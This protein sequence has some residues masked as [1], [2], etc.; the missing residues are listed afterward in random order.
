MSRSE[1]KSA[2]NY[3]AVFAGGIGSRMGSSSTPKQFLKLGGKPIV[4]H[5]LEHFE[6]HTLVDG[7]SIACVSDW[8]EELE[9][10]IINAQLRKV[11]AIVSGGET[12]QLSIRNALEPLV[13]LSG[14]NEAI[15]LVHDGVRPL[16]DE[17]LITACIESVHKFGS[18]IVTAPAAETILTMAS[19]GAVEGI[20]DRKK[21]RLAR[22]PQGFILKELWNAHERALSEGQ[23]DFIDSATMMMHYGHDLVTVEGPARNIKITTPEDFFAFKGFVDMDEMGQ[24]WES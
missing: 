3:V 5:T 1:V 2:K 10:I 14:E 9:R 20:V 12:G 21:C 13:D 16:I 22:A 6:N 19:D 15:V 24:L 7:I 23:N 4:L 8:I 17:G 18:G 11:V